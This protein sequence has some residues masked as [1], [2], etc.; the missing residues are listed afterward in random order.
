MAGSALGD[1]ALTWLAYAVVAAVS[2]DRNWVTRRWSRRQWTTI[3]VA[4]I[5]LAVGVER[6]ALA[7]GRWSYTAANPVIPGI[8]VSA[9]PVLQLLVL[10][11]LT[12]GAGR[13]AARVRA[14]RRA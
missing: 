13:L 7:A 11:P 3:G 14:S 12:F 4:A 1:V 6:L 2:G 8:E 10:L 5:V 9:V